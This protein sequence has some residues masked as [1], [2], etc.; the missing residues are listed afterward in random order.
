M[1]E[2]KLLKFC[3]EVSAEFSILLFALVTFRRRLNAPSCAKQPEPHV[4]G[5]FI[6]KQNNWQLGVTCFSSHPWKSTR[7]QKL[8]TLSIQEAEAPESPAASPPSPQCHISIGVNLQLEPT[9][10]P[11]V[12]LKTP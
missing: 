2:K 10:K 9:P 4:R 12:Q 11:Q 8:F 6:E 3:W 5:S 1:E 7:L